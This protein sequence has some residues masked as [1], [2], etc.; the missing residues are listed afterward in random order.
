MRWDIETGRRMV[1]NGK[2]VPA[3]T[4]VS[5]TGTD[6]KGGHKDEVLSISVSADALYVASGGRDNTIRIWD[7]R[8]NSVVHVFSGQHRD[9]IS[10]LSFHSDTHQLYSGSF[11]RTVKIW[12][13]D[14]MSYVDTLFGHQAEIIDI[15]S[16]WSGIERPITCGRDKTIR[17]WKIVEQSQLVYRA[18]PLS[19]SIDAISYVNGQQFVSA[20]QDGAITLWNASKKKPIS[21]I[22]NA[23]HSQWL[24]S[25][26]AYRNS[27]LLFSGSC[28]GF[29]NVYKI[30]SSGPNTNKLAMINNIAMTG[31]INDIAIADSGKFAIAAVGQEHRLGRWTTIHKAKNGINIVKL[32]H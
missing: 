16:D 2:P 6:H 18:A 13:I 23:H 29:L 21:M 25:V 32:Q 27:D 5:S 11:D 14:Q 26:A 15:D 17:I 10:A 20:S 4:T 28:D 1:M 31:W 8:I 22:K 3:A 24:S 30:E 7:T 9:A 19:L 12:N